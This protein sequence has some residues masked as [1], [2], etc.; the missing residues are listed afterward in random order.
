MASVPY[1]YANT[2]FAN[3]VTK[4]F[5]IPKLLLRVEEIRGGH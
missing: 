4:V 3:L 5:A 2:S 1:L